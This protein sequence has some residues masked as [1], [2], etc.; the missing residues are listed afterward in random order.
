M[1]NNYRGAITCWG[2]VLAVLA[3]FGQFHGLLITI[4]WTINHCFG[5]PKRFLG[6]TIIGVE[7]RVGNQ[8]S[9]FWL[10]LAHFIGY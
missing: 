4:S 8:H 6:L 5:V 10:I 2:S 1:I 3:D 7:L 9:Q